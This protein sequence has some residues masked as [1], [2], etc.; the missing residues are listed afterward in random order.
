LQEKL[1]WF[2]QQP[3]CSWQEANLPLQIQ[4]GAG[5][6]VLNIT[7]RGV[8]L[9]DG[10]E[11]LHFHPNMALL[12]LVNILKG[13]PDRYLQAT[14]LRA[15]DTLLDL[16]LG[17][18]SDAL[19]G[20]WAVGASGKVTGVELSPVISALVKDGLQSLVEAAQTRCATPAKKMAWEALSGA[21]GRIE[22]VWAD[23]FAYLCRQPSRSADVIFFDPMF[24]STRQ[25]S[26]SIRPLH[27][28]SDHRS[29]RREVI[30]EARR[31]AR[32]CLVLKERKGSAEF[33]RLGFKIMPGGRYSPVDYGLIQV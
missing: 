14:G 8:F 31:V 18:G 27:F 15:G 19:V 28:W 3:G 13:E 16:T 11:N 1:A 6:S 26:V 2:M 30:Q 21:A 10:E 20:S 4:T 33:S 5:L 17:L 25:Q 9:H 23:H 24:R 12:R 22:V 29:L 7:R 32:R